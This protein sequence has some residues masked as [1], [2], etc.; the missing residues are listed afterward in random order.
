MIRP[1]QEDEV[2]KLYPLMEQFYL[3]QKTYI[4]PFDWEYIEAN[5][6]L[7]INHPNYLILIDE[8]YT[9]FLIAHVTSN[10]LLP[11]YEGFEDYIYV[12]PDHRGTSR[13]IRLLTDYEEW[14]IEKNIKYSNIGVG[15]GIMNDKVKELYIRCGYSEYYSGFKKELS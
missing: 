15:T 3:E 10:A 7:M 11:I 6:K 13:F 8:E 2:G 5:I 14:L 12:S 9:C 4:E 1:I